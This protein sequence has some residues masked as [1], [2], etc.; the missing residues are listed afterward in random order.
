LN[1]TEATASVTSTFA[2]PSVNESKRRALTAD[3]I[4]F[5]RKGET[6]YAF[7]M[8]WP[9]KQ[10]AIAA[11]ASNSKQAPGK[12]ENVELLGHSGKLKWTRD[13]AGLKI[14]LPEQKPCEHAV[15]FRIVGVGLV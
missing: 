14:E 4:R 2:D 10:A 6:L 5:T 15:A 1:M 9:A 8:G 13:D 3:D 12:I 7:V 11:L